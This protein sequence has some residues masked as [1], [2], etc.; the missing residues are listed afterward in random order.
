MIE[1]IKI[2][3]NRKLEIIFGGGYIVEESLIGILGI[4]HIGIHL[5]HRKE[6]M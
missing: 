5:N 2:Y 1:C 6:I 3:P 4:G